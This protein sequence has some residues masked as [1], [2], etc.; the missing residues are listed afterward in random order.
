MKS[1]E[2]IV[3]NELQQFRKKY[4]LYLQCF[5][6]VANGIKYAVRFVAPAVKKIFPQGQPETH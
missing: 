3:N 2:S 1:S 4:F 5:F 6:L